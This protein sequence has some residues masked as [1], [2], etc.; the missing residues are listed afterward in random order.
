M[1]VLPRVLLGQT[2]TASESHVRRL[3]HSAFSSEEGV[4]FHSLSLPNHQYK[5]LGEADFVLVRPDALLVLEVKG[6]NISVENG[7]WRFE[8]GR[9]EAIV[10]TESPMRQAESAMWAAVDLMKRARLKVPAT[11]GYVVV[12]PFCDW[13]KDKYPEY[14]P[15]LFLDRRDCVDPQAFECGILE[16]EEFW[17]QRAVESG[18]TPESMDVSPYEDALRPSFHAVESLESVTQGFTEESAQLTLEQ[19]TTLDS[20]TANPRILLEGSAGTGKTL[21]CAA[22]ANQA[23][24]AGE[25]VAIV[26][27]TPGLHSLM[28]KACPGVAVLEAAEV[29]AHAASSEPYDVLLVDEGQCMGTAEF[30]KALDGLVHGGIANGRWRWA[31]DRINQADT[32]MAPEVLGHLQTL[33]FRCHLNA[34]LR[35]ARPI[36][37]QLKLVLGADMTVGRMISHG[38]TPHFEDVAPDEMLGRVA[39]T[40]DRWMDQGVR[41]TDVTVIAPIGQ[42]GEIARALPS[43]ALGLPRMNDRTLVT[44]AH[45]YRGLESPAVLIVLDEASPDGWA[46]ERWLYLAMSRA[47]VTLSFLIGP[48]ARDALGQLEKLNFLR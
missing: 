14:P 12:T 13:P 41:P 46:L 25:R 27:P 10:K 34:N 47:R 20:I 9:G 11:L 7:I 43:A 38:V 39:A 3:L 48:S 8:N 15:P 42:L 37:E 30:V 40:V 16:A 29:P 23:N 2:I 1:K 5:R 45:S 36:V 18:R 35:S 19:I 31:M 22:W 44:D 17:R 32:P 21:L 24:R 28:T 6:G 4:A 26:V 33:A